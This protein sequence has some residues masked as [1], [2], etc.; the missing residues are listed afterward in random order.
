M[1]DPIDTNLFG[2]DIMAGEYALGVLEGADLAIAQ[3]RYLS[4]REFAA[5]VEWWRHRLGCMAEA[6]GEFDPSEQVWPAI[7]RRLFSDREGGG[8]MED[9]RVRP[10][11][12]GLPGWSLG[13]GMAI[14][15]AAA[16]ALTFVFV[17]P[18]GQPPVAP[19]ETAAP[20]AGERLVAQL[21]SEDGALTLAG[22]VD[23]QTGQLS[24]NIGGFAPAE[25]QATELWVVPEGG[26]PQSLGLI[27]ASGTFARDLTDAE[28]AALV[29]GA[30]LAVTY[31]DAVSAPHAAPTTDILI[32]GGLTQV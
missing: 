17:Q 22:L 4:D 9:P 26:A 16:A 24:L 28:R 11:T 32:I 29:A 6:A 3:R 19:V 20:V 13:L 1:A 5:R 14:S 10:S 12:R 2:P 23:G 31:E 18:A 27:P 25:G 30:S 8:A 15:A 21:A 7:E